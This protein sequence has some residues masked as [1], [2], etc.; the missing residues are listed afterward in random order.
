[1]Y[2]ILCMDLPNILNA[3][4]EMSFMSVD[5][6]NFCRLYF[7]TNVTL[8]C[9]DYMQVPENMGSLSLLL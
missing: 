1:M 4:I 2:M 5:L 3:I 8:I 7:L 9:Y 6:L